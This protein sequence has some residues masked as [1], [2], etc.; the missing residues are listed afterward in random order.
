[1]GR[2]DIGDYYICLEKKPF[3]EIQI[4]DWQLEDIFSQVREATLKNQEGKALFKQQLTLINAESIPGGSAVAWCS[5]HTKMQLQLLSCPW[6]TGTEKCHFPFVAALFRNSGGAA[7]QV[8]KHFANTKSQNMQVQ[9]VF[10]P[11]CLG[12]QMKEPAS[13]GLMYL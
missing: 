3:V 2:R 4:S 9:I 6:V 10:Y 8:V 5:A 12:A 7:L 13:P 1:M 11:S